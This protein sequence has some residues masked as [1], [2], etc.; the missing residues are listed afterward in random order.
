MDNKND[1]KNLRLFNIVKQQYMA[2]LVES[3]ILE[4]R[5]DH[6]KEPDQEILR[7]F[8]GF[9]QKNQELIDSLVVM[10]FQETIDYVKSTA[11]PHAPTIELTKQQI[12][13]KASN[14]LI[15]RIKEK[16]REI[17]IMPVLISGLVYTITSQEWIITVIFVII[18]VLLGNLWWRGNN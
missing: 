3:F 18:I 7:T 8:N 13:I 9:L 6:N 10:A 11:V 5:N 1:I 15:N 4:Y 14:K 16:Y 12:K 17:I 2:Q